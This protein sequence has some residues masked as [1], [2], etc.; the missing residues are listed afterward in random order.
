VLVLVLGS[1]ATPKIWE[2]LLVIGLGW[3]CPASAL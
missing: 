3:R 2:S 1:P